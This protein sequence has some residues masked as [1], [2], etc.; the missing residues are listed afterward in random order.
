MIFVLKIQD[1]EATISELEA[2]IKN[3]HNNWFRLH[4]HMV[5]M[6]EKLTHI[7]NDSNLARQSTYIPVTRTLSH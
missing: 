2:E 7:S 6:S 5:T 3:D 1:M 4:C